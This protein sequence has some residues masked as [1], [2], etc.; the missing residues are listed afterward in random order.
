MEKSDYITAPSAQS[1]RIPQDNVLHSPLGMRLDGA[2]SSV[3][4][5]T[6]EMGY[7]WNVRL[8][9]YKLAGAATITPPQPFS[10]CR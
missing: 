10:S 1:P 4:D 8:F 7:K 2:L 6:E 9:S 3:S 5:W